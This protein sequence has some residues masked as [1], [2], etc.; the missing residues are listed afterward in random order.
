MGG[1]FDMINRYTD[2]NCGAPHVDRWH[3]WIIRDHE[4]CSKCGQREI[5]T[6]IDISAIAHMYIYRYINRR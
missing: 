2:R 5:I 4:H 3:N 6:I 1:V